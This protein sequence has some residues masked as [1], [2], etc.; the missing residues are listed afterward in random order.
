V[1][2]VHLPL[3]WTVVVDVAVWGAW[4]A[5]VGLAAHLLPTRWLT[6]DGFVLCLRPAERDRSVYRRMRIKR[7]K[8]RLPEAGSLFA[9]GFSKRAMRQRDPAYLERFVVETRRAELTHWWV[10]LAAPFFLLWNPVALG[11][12][13]VVY[14]LAANVPCLLVQRY[15]RARLQRLLD[16]R[17]IVPGRNSGA[18]R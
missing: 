2:V 11:A 7:W 12:V 15:N 16:R 3:G 6:R 10:M 14:A 18:G 5:L 17:R 8:D 4:S 13:M 1:R 9:G